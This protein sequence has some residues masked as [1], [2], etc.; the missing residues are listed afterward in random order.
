M[1]EKWNNLGIHAY[2]KDLGIEIQSMNL[3]KPS[4]K[5]HRHTQTRY[6]QY[7]GKRRDNGRIHIR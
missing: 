6:R 1:A 4:Y 5:S 2:Q 3:K 7:V